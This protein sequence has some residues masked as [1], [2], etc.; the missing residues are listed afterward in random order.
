[1]KINDK[2][3]KTWVIQVASGL[4][5]DFIG[6]LIGSTFQMEAQRQVVGG[7][8]GTIGVIIGL[9]GLI[10]LSAYVSSYVSKNKII[11]SVVLVIVFIIVAIIYSSFLSIIRGV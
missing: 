3:P 11:S 4:C 10:N 8:I 1:M 2:T 6:N 9:I 5:L 7:G